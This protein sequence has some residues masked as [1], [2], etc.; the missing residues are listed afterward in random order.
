MRQAWSHFLVVLLDPPLLGILKL[1]EKKSFR[2]PFQQHSSYVE[3][4]ARIKWWNWGPRSCGKTDNFCIQSW[5][6][7]MTSIR[8]RRGCF[9]FF[10]ITVCSLSITHPWE[11]DFQHQYQILLPQMMLKYA[12]FSSYH[13]H[14]FCK[15]LR[16]E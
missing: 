15:S 5:H 7:Y 3:G 9:F 16:E 1:S 12:A 14:E 13:A 6:Q 10:T 4:I 8:G 2:L 11:F